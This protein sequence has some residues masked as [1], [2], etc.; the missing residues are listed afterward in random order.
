MPPSQQHVPTTEEQASSVVPV[1]QP[2]DDI[3]DVLSEFESGLESLKAL[4]V[5]R[6][7]L[8]TRIRDQEDK[9]KQREDA[10]GQRAAEV[11]RASLENQ[12]KLA[13]LEQARAALEQ[14]ERELAETGQKLVQEKESELAA[15]AKSL[16]DQERKIAQE[17]QTHEQRSSELA[18]KLEAL[19]QELGQ[20]ESRAQQF[21][22]QAEQLKS[23]A[24]G[25]D[26][27]LK[28]AA[29]RAAELEKQVAT[30][31]GEAQRLT[32]ALAKHQ[33]DAAELEKA[34]SV[35]RARFKEEVES[36]DQIRTRLETAEAGLSQ[37]NARAEGLQTKLSALLTEVA[38]FKEKGA[39]KAPVSSS[40]A[41]ILR[42]RQRLK[43]YRELV[44]E[45]S[46]KVR[47]ANEALKKKV[48]T[49]E[50]VLAHRSELAAIRDRVLEGERRLQRRQASSR[51][52]VILLC[53]VGV[54]GMLA[55]LSWALAREV[56]PATYMA[57]SELK[58]EGKGR[59]LTQPELAEWNHFHEGLLADPRFHETAAERFKRVGIE[60]LSTPAAVAEM[61][62]NDLTNEST[63]AGELE[64]HLKGLGSDRTQRTLE[65]FTAALASH[66]NAAQSSRIDGGVTVVAK[67]A[68]SGSEPLD[69]TRTLYALVI[70]SVGASASLFAFVV[71]WKRLAR[72]K[73][74]FE[75]DEVVND[76][77]DNAHWAAFTAAAAAQ[78]GSMSAKNKAA[79]E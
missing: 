18:Q 25:A 20:A 13:E 7:K 26:R 53:A 75:Q 10:L 1:T 34:L 17:A 55:A 73:T 50:Q 33:T 41:S 48:E 4:Y 60:R 62:R 54:L 79:R 74:A 44:R 35:L 21:A 29:A 43:I 40:A 63:N 58:G 71:L 69:G 37:A 16:E 22:K 65:T 11:E 47:R 67:A 39:A 9:C 64:L 42:R 38:A 72:A 70:L 51:A 49:C 15:R 28:D 32:A 59:E 30:E 57:T 68:A 77:L 14:R 61:V 12:R 5:Q 6:Q 76:A 3:L 46:L 2:G 24:G 27:A 31:K 36:R 8:Q 56:A 66:A 52:S 23:G 19:T 45:Q 78:Q